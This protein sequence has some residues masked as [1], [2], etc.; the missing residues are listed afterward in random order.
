VRMFDKMSVE[1]QQVHLENGA[2]YLASL[3]N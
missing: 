3:D 1:K 2:V